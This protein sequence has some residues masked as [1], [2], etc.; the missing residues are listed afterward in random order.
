MSFA[1]NKDVIESNRY[2]CDEQDSR[3]VGELGSDLTNN[4]MSVPGKHTKKKLGGMGYG[5]SLSFD[6]SK[7]ES[8]DLG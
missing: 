3:Q 4:Q 1:Q 8:L 7:L 5:E 2:K 6:C